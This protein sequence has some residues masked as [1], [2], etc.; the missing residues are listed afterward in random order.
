MTADDVLGPCPSPGHGVGAAAAAAL[1][2]AADHVDQAA[3]GASPR[4]A[5]TRLSLHAEDLAHSPV[6]RD[7]LLSRALE[8]AAG[9]LAEGRRPLSHWPLFFA[10][11][12]SPSL[13]A[14]EDVR[15]WVLAGADP[16]LAD[17]EAVAE[18]VEARAVRELG[19]AFETARGLTRRL[20]IEAWLQLALWD[21]PRIPANAETR[22]LM[23]AGGR[24]LM[25]RVGD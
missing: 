24:R 6:A 21:D 3:S 11:D 8:L 5:A 2:A 17:G 19:D 15:A 7:Q 12:L 23:R 18:A 22:F 20:R 25:A 9:D 14:R 13:E 4:E 10:E 16:M 1:L